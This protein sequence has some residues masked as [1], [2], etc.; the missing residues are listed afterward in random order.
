MMKAEA[1]MYTHW[2][3]EIEF[4]TPCGHVLQGEG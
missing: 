1:L 3:A 4:E 2:L